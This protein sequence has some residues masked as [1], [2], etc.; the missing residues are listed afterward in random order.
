MQSTNRYISCNQHTH[1]HKKNKNK[2]KERENEEEERKGTYHVAKVS[3]T[4]QKWHS[5]F[6]SIDKPRNVDGTAAR[7]NLILYRKFHKH[8]T[9]GKTKLKRTALPVTTINYIINC[10]L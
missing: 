10:H 7:R 6:L 2:K 5:C 4:K 8:D 3:F 9:A 1:T